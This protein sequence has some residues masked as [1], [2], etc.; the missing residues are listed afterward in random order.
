[1]TNLQTQPER[2]TTETESTIA[3]LSQLYVVKYFDGQSWYWSGSGNYLSNIN[4]AR[5]Y[6]TKEHAQLVADS[7]LATKP[8]VIPVKIVEQNI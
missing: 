5:L 6:K 3:D 4:E 1:M 2:I 8:Q 7:L